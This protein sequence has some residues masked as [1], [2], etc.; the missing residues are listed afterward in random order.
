M[1]GTEKLLSK[2]LLNHCGSM[3]PWIGPWARRSPCENPRAEI[4]G[5]CPSPSRSKLSCAS[6]WAQ[7]RKSEAELNGA[8]C[9]PQAGLRQEADTGLQTG[10][11]HL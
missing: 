7:P 10:L 3:S 2:Q 9:L 1:S 11:L 5:I 4:W 8:A 6:H